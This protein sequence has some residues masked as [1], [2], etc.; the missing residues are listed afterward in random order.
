M[1]NSWFLRET[2]NIEVIEMKCPKC[3]ASI[4]ILA[5]KCPKCLSPIVVEDISRISEDVISNR[6]NNINKR[7]DGRLE[8]LNS[9]LENR[10]KLLQDKV[11]HRLSSDYLSEEEI[12]SLF[13]T[14]II[15]ELEVIQEGG[16]KSSLIHDVEEEIKKNLG[17]S[18]Y[19]HYKKKGEDVLKIIRSGEFCVRLFNGLP[20]IDLSVIMFPFF[21]AAEKSCWL[22]T[23]KRYESLCGDPLIKQIDSW[24]SIDAKNLQIENVPGWM[25]DR[26]KTVTEVIQGLYIKKEFFTAGCLRTGIALYIFGR[27]WIM[28][29]YRNDLS[30]AKKFTIENILKVSGSDA[31]KE[32]LASDLQRLQKLRNDRVHKEVESDEKYMLISKDLSYRCLRNITLIF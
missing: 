13:D 5:K 17:D 6:F 32:N 4:S 11:A 26:T 2:I 15:P 23:N 19:N 7:I 1:K 8:K 28:E 30:R 31:E 3:N 14:E 29:I 25:K 9:R 22:Y 12:D 20:S 27:R 21:K 18:A 10:I 24:V 16:D